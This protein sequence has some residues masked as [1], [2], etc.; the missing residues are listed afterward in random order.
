M[1]S[2]SY[3]LTMHERVPVIRPV[4][5]AVGIVRVSK[6]AGREGDSFVSPTD[7]RHSIHQAAEREALTLG[8]TDIF[9]ELDVSGGDPLTRRPGLTEALRR[10]ES[11]QAQ[12][13]VV[14]YFDRLF[15]K[16]S[17]QEQVLERVEAAGG[18]VLAVD[19]GEIRTDTASRWLSSTMLGMVAEYHRRITREK[20]NAARADAIGRGVPTFPTI[21]PGY[22]RGANGH[23]EPDES[24]AALVRQAFEMRAAGAALFEIRDFFKAHGIP[25]SYRS[26][27]TLL[28]SRIV[29]GELRSG[30]FVN[31]FA[32]AP[33]VD[34]LLWQR[35]QLTR[36]P[37]GPRSPSERLL[38]RL[39]ILR[40]ATCKAAMV[41]TYGYKQRGGP[42]YWKYHCGN[43]DCTARAMISAAVIET[44]V[45]ER[46]RARLA[47]E[48]E[49]AAID[50]DVAEAE[51]DL[52]Q[53]QSLLAAA[54]TAFDG[55]NVLA[56]RTRLLELQQ[57]VSKADERLAMLRAASAPARVIN[58]S[59]DWDALLVDEQRDLIRVL[60][61]PIEV[62]PG[63]ASPRF[64][65]RVQ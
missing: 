40:C 60:V 57:A 45:V 27:Q 64:E 48:T 7:Q 6:V 26:T 19:A 59:G 20:T 37:R 8:D 47:Q 16:L 36:L 51:E 1:S 14:A 55:L 61:T 52:A 4:R 28:R 3:T 43:R 29:L 35:A 17:V 10:I 23:L 32:H 53:S 15:R 9:E 18:T 34:Q 44:A 24:E 65:I 33:I 25:R 58:A 31:K 2:T 63:R 21:I 50:L 39:G 11:G 12:V 5:Q 56:A 62:R 49:S 42:R 38:A 13:L 30:T 54:V 22:R 46:V 41:A